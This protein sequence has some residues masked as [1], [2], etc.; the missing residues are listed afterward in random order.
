[1]GNDLEQFMDGIAEAIE[2]GRAGE[3]PS[4]I[5]ANTY[6]FR[7]HSMSDAM[8]YRSKDEMERAKLRDP[9]SLYEVSL[10]DAGLLTDEQAEQMEE[11]VNQEVE[12]AIR[13]AD[14]DPHPPLE[15]R[16]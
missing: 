13:Q 4:Y 12:E 3:G 15:S 6:R 16:F 10:R 7:G 5:V 2:R 11:A 8:K 1:D 9:I 14:E